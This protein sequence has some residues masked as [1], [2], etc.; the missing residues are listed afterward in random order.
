MPS[1]N[2]SSRAG[3]LEIPRVTGAMLAGP[4]CGAAGMAIFGTATTGTLFATGT[5]LMAMWGIG[6]A[7]EQRIVM[8]GVSVSEQGELQRA[9]GSLVGVASLLGRGL[10]TLTYARSIEGTTQG[11]LPGR[12]GWSRRS[13]S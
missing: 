2:I 8:R 12:H 5:P 11:T 4:L 9:L 1:A 10:F 7:A 3:A 6:S 13:C